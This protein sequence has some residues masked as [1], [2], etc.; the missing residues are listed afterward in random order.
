[1]N[2]T[3]KINKVVRSNGVT[4]RELAELLP[5]KEQGL[6][7]AFRR[8]SVKDEYLDIIE[9]YLNGNTYN[10]LSEPSDEYS[11]TTKGK[12]VPYY[13]VDFI[14]GFDEVLNSQESRP[15]YYIDHPAYNNADCW[16]NVTGKSMSPFIS[17]GDIIAVKQ[18][19]NWDSF[20]LSGEIYAIVTESFRTIKKI[21]VED[22]KDYITLIPQNKSSEFT[23]QKLPKNLIQSVFRVQGCIKRFF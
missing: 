6:A 7:L 16:V 3:E 21:K 11:I 19:L 12:G 9:R 4:Y 5:I 8:K 15:M 22:D 13:D 1:M 23:E 17:H 10:T 14:G 18:E 20:L 2:R